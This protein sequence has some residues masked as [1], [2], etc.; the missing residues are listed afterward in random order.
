VAN[1]YDDG[2][3]VTGTTS[4]QMDVIRLFDERG[5]VHPVGQSLRHFDQAG[6]VWQVE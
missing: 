2:F 5:G 6:N 3:A 4:M 1:G